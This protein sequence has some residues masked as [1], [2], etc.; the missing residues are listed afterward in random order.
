MKQRYRNM[1]KT[2]KDDL[3]FY[4]SS[5]V[6][7]L[8]Y[9]R[10]AAKLKTATKLAV[11]KQNAFNKTYYVLLDE[12]NSPASYSWKQIRE[13]QKVGLIAPELPK[14]EI[15][16]RALFY[17]SSDTKEQMTKEQRKQKRKDYIKY[18]QVLTKRKKG[19]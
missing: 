15:K 7:G 13:L 17:T 18:M 4:A 5:I 12:N 19:Y 6:R 11:L 16:N 2:I 9:I 3:K 14:Y 1:I 10:F 8:R